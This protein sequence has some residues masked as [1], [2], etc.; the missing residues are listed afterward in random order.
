MVTNWERIELALKKH[1][2]QAPTYGDDMGTVL[3]IIADGI[4]AMSKN[5]E[6]LEFEVNL[7]K[8]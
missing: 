3:S 7:L 5:I 2:L 6:G 1:D 8:I 4:E